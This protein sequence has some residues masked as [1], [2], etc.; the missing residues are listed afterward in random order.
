MDLEQIR[1]L[2]GVLATPVLHVEQRIV[3]FD[4]PTADSFH[5]EVR[6]QIRIP[7]SGSDCEDGDAQR[8]Y[9]VSL[10][11]FDKASILGFIATG[12]ARSGNG[13]RLSILPMKETARILSDLLV[14]PLFRMVNYEY[15]GAG[16][17]VFDLLESEKHP[18]ADQAYRIIEHVRRS[19][20]AVIEA[21]ETQGGQE[22]AT[23]T[24]L[25]EK[26]TGPEGGWPAMAA[27]LLCRLEPMV[28]SSHVLVEVAGKPGER[29]TVT[30]DFTRRLSDR[31]M[32]ELWSNL[33][34]VGM[35]SRSAILLRRVLQQLGM[36]PLIYRFDGSEARHAALTAIVPIEPEGT[37][38]VRSY[39]RGEFAGPGT[40]TSSLSTT[41]Q[42]QSKELVYSYDESTFNHRG[43][44]ATFEFQ[45]F[46]GHWLTLAWIQTF[47][48][49]FLSSLVW[50]GVLGPQSANL[51]YIFGIPAGVIASISLASHPFVAAVSRPIRRLFL[52]VALLSFGYVLGFSSNVGNLPLVESLPL[53]RVYNASVGGF[54]TFLAIASGYSAFGKQA[55]RGEPS[56][57]SNTYANVRS[58]KRRFHRRAITAFL[59]AVCLSFAV[60][61]LMLLVKKPTG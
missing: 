24:A 51:V 58:S 34:G 18:L 8:N 61:T 29:V 5:S 37:S 45:A 32:R 60:G 19:T 28:K 12:S 50:F 22:I 27:D 16:Y 46:R 31:G 9:I 23:L 52:V 33:A 57:S 7:E 20:V 26:P 4:L 41:A 21:D 39:W 38:I 54:C 44:Q 14:V 56:S 35:V 30:S 11:P 1:L 10:G 3:T 43:L 13:Q 48:L 17:K 53:L 40:G 6:L 59:L 25:L 49:L 55:L 36:L 42:G 2:R 15:E 47:A